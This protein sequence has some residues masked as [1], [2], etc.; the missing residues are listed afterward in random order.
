MARIISDNGKILTRQ[1][2]DKLLSVLLRGV[3]N[4]F[5]LVVTAGGYIVTQM[6]FSGGLVIRYLG[7]G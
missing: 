1:R 4:L 5:A 3:N 2:Q 6:K 7:S